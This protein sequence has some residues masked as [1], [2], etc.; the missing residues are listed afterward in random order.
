ML[1]SRRRLLAL[2]AALA[3]SVAAPA[4]LRAASFARQP[5][6]LFVGTAAAGSNDLVAR[7]IAPTFREIFDQPVL[8][9]NRPGAATTL[10]AGFV[11]NAKPDGHTLLVS[12]AAAIAVHVASVNK[13]VNLVEDLSHVG[14]A[15]D[16]AYVYALHKDVPAADAEAFVAL[17][18]REPGR[19]RYGATGTG[20]SIHMSGELFCLNTGTKMTAVQYTNAGMRANEL[21]ANQTQLGIAGA[22]VLGQHIRTGALKGLFV[23]G[24]Q[25]DKLFPELPTSREVGIKGLETISNW[26]ALHGPKGMPDHIIAQLNDALRKALAKPETVQGLTASGLFP[27]PGTQ[28]ALIERM[29]LDYSVMSDVAKRGGI[30]IE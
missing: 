2:P 5:I 19:L 21:L 1:F 11:A 26:F 25:R 20:G 3:A 6:R 7:L 16:G 22:A 28:Q 14:M 29:K 8:V 9:E 17:L 4:V 13:P 12:S 24:E 10:A 27:T 23:A 15:C 30:R 18:K